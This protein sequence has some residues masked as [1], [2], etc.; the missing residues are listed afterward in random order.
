MDAYF[1]TLNIKYNIINY[2]LYQIILLVKY[3]FKE[4]LLPSKAMKLLA[5]NA[6]AVHGHIWALALLAKKADAA[7]TKMTDE[8]PL[9]NGI[10]SKYKSLKLM[11]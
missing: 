2:Y 7:S 8:M 5:A 4:Q 1:Y 11:N 9:F 3:N 10:S 6:S